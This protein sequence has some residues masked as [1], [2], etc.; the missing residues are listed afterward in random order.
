ME[1]TPFI[2]KLNINHGPT[3]SYPYMAP[4]NVVT[5]RKCINFFL[6]I[7]L[8]HAIP[9]FASFLSFS[10]HFH[11]KHPNPATLHGTQRV[12]G[13]L[14]SLKPSFCNGYH[15]ICMLHGMI[16]GTRYS[17]YNKYSLLMHRI[18]IKSS[19]R[20]LW[21]EQNVFVG[22]FTAL[23]SALTLA[24]LQWQK[25]LWDIGGT[26]KQDVGPPRSHGAWCPHHEQWAYTCTWN[27]VQ[28][29]YGS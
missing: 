23:Q 22:G 27:F 28:Y 13:L 20:L 18:K 11:C 5:Y 15:A 19:A 24:V 10:L 2:C 21:N 4:V 29:I 8:C 3:Q 25:S 16:L 1:P 26:T 17:L 7:H 14:T 12:N 9:V 6:L